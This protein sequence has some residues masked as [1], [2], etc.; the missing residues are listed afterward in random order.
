MKLYPSFDEV[1]VNDDLKGIFYPLCS[2]EI[3]DKTLHFVSHNGMWLNKQFAT[4]YNTVNDFRFDCVD[5]KYSFKGDI[6]LYRGNIEA[7][8]IFPFLEKDFEKNGLKYFESKCKTASYFKKIK[9]NLP[10]IKNDEFDLDYYLETFYVFSIN[11]LHYENNSQFG[12]FN[13]I[14][15]GWGKPDFLPIYYYDALV[16]ELEELGVTKAKESHQIIGKAVGYNYFTDGNDT[17]LCYHAENE[18]VILYNAYS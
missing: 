15:N 10:E 13:H 1:F 3:A 9:K 2:V 4:E 8:V 11:K 17:I 6:R 12:G 14:I 7:K 16:N 5:N 18:E